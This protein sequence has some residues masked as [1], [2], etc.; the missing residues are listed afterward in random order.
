VSPNPASTVDPVLALVV[1]AILVLASMLV[2]WPRRGLLA[3]ALHLRHSSER[4]RMEDALKHLQ[5]LEHRGLA[6]S[7]ESLAGVLGVTR[8]VAGRTLERLAERGLVSG[9]PSAPMLT[10]EGRE[11][12]VRILRTHRLWERYLADRT[13]V[14]PELWHAL[15]EEA[16]HAL[17]P[18][19]TDAL[20]S[21]LGHPRYDPHGDPIPTSAGEVPPTPGV[22]L[23]VVEPGQSAE[24]T[25]L[26][27]EP[28]EVFESLTAMG[29]SPQLRLT[30][31][32]RS[33]RGVRVQVGG[34]ER[35]LDSMAA[36]NVTVR[37]LAEDERVPAASGTLAELPQ[38][39]AARVVRISPACQGPQRRR[40][41]DLGVVPGTVIRAELVSS[42][43]DPVAYEIRGALIA[44][45]RDQARLIEVDPGPR[46]ASA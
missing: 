27:D 34:E 21:R 2:W 44:L 24:I 6:A 19:E 33:D 9:V 36:A 7:V 12:A 30:V 39:E 15:A 11:Y 4:V 26:E 31:L 40:L 25:H 10:E 8:M 22:P 3:R 18:T 16:E 29:L 37:T 13:G 41:L 28:P 5:D 32:A 20:A 45:R 46:A 35:A 14:K 17:T 1:F 43:G 42:G 38:G 23:T